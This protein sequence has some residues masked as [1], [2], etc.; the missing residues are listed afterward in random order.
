[1]RYFPTERGQQ[2]S[3][4]P[5]TLCLTTQKTTPTH[6]ERMFSLQYR[7]QS[8]KRTVVH[9]Q[10]TAWPELYGA[11]CLFGVSEG[12]TRSN[13]FESLFVCVGPQGPP[14]QQEQPAALHPGGA[15]TLP[16][17]EAPTHTCCGALQVRERG[18]VRVREVEGE[19]EGER[20]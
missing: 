4:G 10:F 9:L 5:L 14:R 16:P 15:R 20:E 2:L 12:E 11:S 13:L 8:L 3:Q 7:D 19:G 1:M 6:V 17:P 18:R